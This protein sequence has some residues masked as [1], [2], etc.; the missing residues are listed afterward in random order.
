M[1]YEPFAE[2][3][4]FIHHTDPRIRIVFATIFSITIALSYNFVPLS[5]ALVISIF[6]VLMARLDF[7]QVIKRLTVIMGFTVF[8]WIF[9]PFTYEGEIIYKIG[10]LAATKQGIT[11]SAQISIK[12]ISIFL[13]FI[14]LV[15]TMPVSTLGYSLAKLKMPPKL[16]HLLL[17]NYR[18]IFVINQEYQRLVTA[19]KIRGF[20]PGTNIHSYKTY[21]YLVGMLFVR[22][23]LRAQ[24]VFNAMKCRGFNGKFY[25]LQEFT[26]NSKAYYFSLFMI[27]V[28]IIFIILTIIPE[29]KLI[30]W[31]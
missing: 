28:I 31:R 11:L 27:T 10:P 15:A 2:G 13:A 30:V 7:R 18:Y 23:S 21:A 20:T 16:V 3:K 25:C 14:A 6:L 4:S 22:A 29:G 1:I 9:L 24:R 8:I 17:F 12:S 5:F 19:A 26:V